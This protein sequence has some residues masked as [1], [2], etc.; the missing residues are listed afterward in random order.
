MLFAL[1]GCADEIPTATG[2]GLFPGGTR[3]VT[4]EVEFSPDESATELGRFSGFADPSAAGFLLVA[5][6]FEGELFAHTLARFTGFPDSVTYTSEGSTTT[7]TAFTFGA[8][9]VVAPIDTAAST[10]AGPVTFR[11]WSLAQDWDAESAGWELAIDSAG[12][13]VPWAEPGGAP[14]ELLAEVTRTPGD[15]LTRDSIVWEVDSLTVQRMA[16]AEFPGVLV[17]ADGSPARFELRRLLLRTALRPAARPDT[18]IAQTISAGPQIFVFVPDVPEARDGWLVGGLMGDRVLLRIRIPES[19]PGCTS[20]ATTP[21]PACAPIPL[22]EVTLN[23]AALLLDPLPVGG[24]RPLA[25]VS[26][27]LRRIGEPELGRIAP[28]GNLVNP[29]GAPYLAPPDAWEAPTD[30]VLRLPITAFVRELALQDSTGA[31]V[32]LLVEPQLRNFGVA[33]FAGRPRLRLVYTLPLNGSG[34]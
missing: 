33:R 15:T 31:A 16:R 24:F 11:L 3:P 22:T 6:R 29:G 4:A 19:V 25:P 9:R 18:A 21:P 32:A 23:D 28:L 7:D 13:Q 17:T 12:R 1:A 14:G 26:L 20:P 10:S 8:G 2:E 30:T 27:V 34:S 5:N